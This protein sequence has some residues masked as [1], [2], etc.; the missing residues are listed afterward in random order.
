MPYKISIDDIDNSV[1]IYFIIG[2]SASGKTT[3][4]TKISNLLE[5]KLISMD[6]IIRKI[7]ITHLDGMKITKLYK[8]NK[9][10]KEKKQVIKIIKKLIKL[11]KNVI[12]EGT[13][14]DPY[15]IDKIAGN[16][17]FRIIYI[18][19]KTKKRYIDNIFKRVKYD[20]DNNTKKIAIV[21]KS[22]TNKEINNENKLMKFIKN[23]VNKRFL[24]HKE[25]Y[26]IYKNYDLYIL[27]N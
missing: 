16:K 5:Y 13:I 18:Q 21:W 1:N 19:P 6:E 17:K 22:L 20:I 8:P 11:H 3:L 9:Y 26:E 10:I 23:L 7:A 15:I 24:Q 4:A 12:I 2:M 27:H 25:V 14:W